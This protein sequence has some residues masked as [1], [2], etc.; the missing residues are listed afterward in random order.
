MSIFATA[1]PS[2]WI[3]LNVRDWNSF[4]LTTVAIWPLSIYAW[5]LW[6]SGT[7][8]PCLGLAI[9][10][11]SFIFFRGLRWEGKPPP[12]LLEDSESSSSLL[13]LESVDD[14]PKAL[15]LWNI[16]QRLDDFLPRPS[17]SCTFSSLA[18]WSKLAT[19]L[20]ASWI[21]LILST[22][23]RLNSPS[24]IG[25]CS[26]SQWQHFFFIRG[27]CS[28]CYCHGS[29]IPRQNLMTRIKSS[30]KWGCRIWM[31]FRG[32]L[33]DL[34]VH[35]CLSVLLVL[36]MKVSCLA[37][38]TTLSVLLHLTYNNKLTTLHLL[39]RYYCRYQYR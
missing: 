38:F 14:S 22:S 39:Y 19:Q 25:A 15:C 31:Y 13:S 27:S 30:W 23:I 8:P 32:C 12:L 1:C 7:F 9:G 24:H 33:R 29:S 11:L 26:Q 4:A 6:W 16:Q 3:I 37:A 2:F 5:Y 34:I 17:L 20:H 36:W 28:L 35:I 10:F 21:H 18:K